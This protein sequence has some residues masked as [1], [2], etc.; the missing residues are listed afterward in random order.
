MAQVKSK[1]SQRLQA[2]VKYTWP[3]CPKALICSPAVLVN[4]DSTLVPPEECADQA[5]I[6][7]ESCFCLLI[8]VSICL[9]G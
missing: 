1:P 6:C 7:L 9:Q 2:S 5:S 8:L 4:Q 3:F